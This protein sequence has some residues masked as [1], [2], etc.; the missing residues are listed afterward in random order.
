MRLQPVLG[1]NGVGHRT[2]PSLIVA[3]IMERGDRR[4]AEKYSREDAK[5]PSERNKH[6]TVIPCAMQ[7]ESAASQTRD[8]ACQ[9]H[10]VMAGFLTR[11]P[12]KHA[13]RQD[14]I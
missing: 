7:H 2:A 4:E 14:G 13:C 10:S 1:K 3:G 11:P 6:F 9:K 12:R 5:S 8:P